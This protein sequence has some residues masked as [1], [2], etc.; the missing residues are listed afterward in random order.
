MGKR[1]TKPGVGLTAYQKRT[2]TPQG[3]GPNKRT[4]LTYLDPYFGDGGKD[5]EF[6]V[7][8][9]IEKAT[10]NGGLIFKVVW[11]Q[12]G[13][14]HDKIEDTWESPQNIKGSDPRILENFHFKWDQAQELAAKQA[15]IKRDKRQA[16]A[17]A[18]AARTRETLSLGGSGPL[19]LLGSQRPLARRSN[20]AASSSSAGAAALD[21]TASGDLTDAEG[22]EATFPLLF[23]NSVDFFKLNLNFFIECFVC[24]ECFVSKNLSST[25]SIDT[26]L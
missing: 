26:T 10:S 3:S 21:E 9:V 19:L 8:N 12:L 5:V 15:Q 4:P 18:E 7:Q 2:L 24:F 20:G 1:A 23:Q 22:N 25:S 13:A 17:Q 6:T 16:T 11:K 14:G